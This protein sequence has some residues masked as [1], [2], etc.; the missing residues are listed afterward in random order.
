MWFMMEPGF[1]WTQIG[2][3]YHF[4]L[5]LLLT[6]KCIF[7]DFHFSVRIQT[8]TQLSD[9]LIKSSFFFTLPYYSLLCFM[10]FNCS[11]QIAYYFLSSQLS[12]TFIEVKIMLVDTGIKDILPFITVVYTNLPLFFKDLKACHRVATAFCCFNHSPPENIWFFPSFATTV[13]YCSKHRD[14]I[15]CIFVQVFL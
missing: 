2:V 7:L 13:T 1:E 8:N 6:S 10:A 15:Y 12:V 11:V 3:L 9:L 4:P 14:Y 5:P